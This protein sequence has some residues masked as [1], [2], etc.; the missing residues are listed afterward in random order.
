MHKQKVVL[1]LCALLTV[2]YHL[3]AQR[4]IIDVPTSEIVEKNHLYFQEQ[5]TFAQAHVIT[6]TVFTRGFGHGF[7]AGLTLN[8]LTFRNERH[9]HIIT[10]DPQI[11]EENPDLMINA[12]KGFEWQDWFTLAVGTHTGIITARH[13]A[14]EKVV[15]FD[16][17]N[18][19]F[20]LPDSDNKLILGTYGGNR[21][22]MGEEGHQFGWMAGTEIE[23]IPE[24]LNFMGE[25]ISGKNTLSNFNF[26][27]QIA[28]PKDW[29]LAIA[30][31]LPSPGSSNSSA[32]VFQIAR[33]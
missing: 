27:I 30:L 29:Q 24:K 25:Y 1:L 2:S 4:N 33:K 23:I 6:S 5:I 14:D 15:T 20:S 13:W 7:E 32:A 12:Q 8:Q 9:R 21:A 3:I 22:Y 18:T 17:I 28:L 31:Q 16:Y 11:P 26:A 19:R 10:V